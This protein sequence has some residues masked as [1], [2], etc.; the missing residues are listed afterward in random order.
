VVSLANRSNEAA[1]AV[2][3]VAD[4][5]GYG[6]VFSPDSAT[7]AYLKITPSPELNAAAAVVGRAPAAERALRRAM[8]NNRLAATSTIAL[9]DLA[10]GRETAI[11]VENLA[12]ASLVMG[13]GGAVFFSG[14]EAAAGAP[15]QIYRA[16]DARAASAITSGAGDKTPVLVNAC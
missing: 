1:L 7:V 10:S 9:R 14:A 13:P 12:K 8:L 5:A 15:Q 11:A 2:R 6:A 16:S 4:L 3:P